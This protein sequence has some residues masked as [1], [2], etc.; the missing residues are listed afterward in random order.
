MLSCA[1][2]TAHGPQCPFAKSNWEAFGVFSTVTTEHDPARA[3]KQR[4]PGRARGPERGRG[5]AARGSGSQRQ[6]S[7]RRIKK[8]RAHAKALYYFQKKKIGAIVAAPR[9]LLGTDGIS[10]VV[11]CFKILYHFKVQR[12]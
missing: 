6:V 12:T 2:V 7:K 9:R 1:H 11:A 8:Y 4:L 5:R 3:A 10:K